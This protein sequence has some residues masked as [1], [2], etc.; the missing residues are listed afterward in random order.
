MPTIPID[1][2][3]KQ[4][5]SMQ[6]PRKAVELQSPFAN[7]IITCWDLLQ[8]T[9]PLVAATAWLEIG[10]VSLPKVNAAD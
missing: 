4:V 9:I 6:L 10:L 7:G 8:T 5:R 1:A 3:V 2:V